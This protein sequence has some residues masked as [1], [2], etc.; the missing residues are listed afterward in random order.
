MTHNNFFRR[1]YAGLRSTGSGFIIREDGLIVT[2]AHIVRDMDQ[3]T[4]KI[5]DG[6]TFSA[7]VLAVDYVSDLAAIKIEAVS[8]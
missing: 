5:N 6:R 3:V 4:V 8:L 7:R 2:N 1:Y